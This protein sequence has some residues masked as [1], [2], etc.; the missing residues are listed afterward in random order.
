MLSPDADDQAEAEAMGWSREDELEFLRESGLLR[1]YN[2][3][4]DLGEAFSD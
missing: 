4:G 1:I 3:E 2:I